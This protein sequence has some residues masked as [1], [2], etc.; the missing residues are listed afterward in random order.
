MKREKGR[1]KHC[2]FTPQ[3]DDANIW[4]RRRRI[5]ARKEKGP[6]PAGV[7]MRRRRKMSLQRRVRASQLASKVMACRSE[8][9]SF[10]RRLAVG[11][12][13]DGV[14]LGRPRMWKEDASLSLPLPSSLPDLLHPPLPVLLLLL[15]SSQRHSVLS[16]S[17]A[18]SKRLLEQEQTLFN[19]LRRRT[20]REN[21]KYF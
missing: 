4:R 13:R 20:K 5:V 18:A 10:W 3:R 16:L 19:D 7:E 6:P 12:G 21:K 17:P 15:P 14:W 9:V 1:S 2:R 11:S 8:G